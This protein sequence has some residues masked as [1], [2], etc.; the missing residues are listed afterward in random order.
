MLLKGVSLSPKSFQPADFT[1]FLNRASQAGTVVSWASDWSELGDDKG[2]P[3]TVMELASRYHYVPALEAQFFLP[4]NG[5]VLRP[6]DEATKKSYK[7]AAVGFAKRYAPPY[8][9]LG[10]EVNVLY[11]K[12][13]A[14]FDTFVPFYAEM[15][16]VVKAVSPNTKVFTVFQLEEM[17]G[18]N[19]GLF[20]GVNDP[21]KAQWQLLEKFPKLDMVGFTTYPAL[22]YKDPAIIPAD[23]YVEIKA[24]TS[25]PIAFTEVG[26]HSAASPAGWESS[27]AEQAHFV[28]RFFSL[29]GGLDLEMAIWSFM[30]DQKVPEPFNSMGLRKGDGSARAAWNEWVKAR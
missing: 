12:S 21:A 30:Y 11:E 17:K 3:R 2:A 1:D 19:G 15:Y 28:A 29:T 9:A 13:P 23:Y 10:I 22:I 25:R 7:N 18:L 26:W 6:L 4:S 14:D 5:R 16:D 20:G 24:H 27:E 8:L